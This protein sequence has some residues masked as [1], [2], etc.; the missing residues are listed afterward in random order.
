MES[1]QGNKYQSSQPCKILWVILKMDN[2]RTQINRSEDKKTD[3][4]A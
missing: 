1:A 4:H 2:G 3:D